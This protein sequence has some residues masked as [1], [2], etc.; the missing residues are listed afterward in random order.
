MTID[1][2]G[3]IQH[4]EK[5]INGKYTKLV[6]E[7]LTFES[8]T[9]IFATDDIN[10]LNKLSEDD[11][12]KVRCNLTCHKTDKFIFHEPKAILI[13]ILEDK[14]FVKVVSQ[15][16]FVLKTTA[17]KDISELQSHFGSY[18]DDIL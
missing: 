2:E 13:E 10:Y 14:E 4:I 1:A 12:I 17:R 7:I 3:T 16:A 5:V 18:G 6:L 9:F 15:K 8:E 11:Y